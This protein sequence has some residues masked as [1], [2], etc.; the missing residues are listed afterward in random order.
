M[1]AKPFSNFL[2]T[3]S[4]TNSSALNRRIFSLLAPGSRMTL[5]TPSCAEISV[6]CT[7]VHIVGLYHGFIGFR[8]GNS[9]RNAST[10]SMDAAV[11]VHSRLVNSS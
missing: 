7:P 9:C 6:M 11:I 10:R 5:R 8:N 1:R 3:L 2:T 4:S